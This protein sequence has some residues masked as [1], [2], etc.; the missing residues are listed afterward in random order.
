MAN[1]RIDWQSSP[2]VFVRRLTCPHCDSG[3]RPLIVR[4][5]REHEEVR[6]RYLCRTC[7]QPFTIIIGDDHEDETAV[8]SG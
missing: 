4:T 6:R 8:F 2:V 5:E 1:D 3:E 7:S